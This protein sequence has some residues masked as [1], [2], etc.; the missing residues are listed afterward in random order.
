MKNRLPVLISIIILIIL[1]W[2]SSCL[3]IVVTP[4]VVGSIWKQKNSISHASPLGVTRGEV[5]VVTSLYSL[6]YSEDQCLQE[7]TQTLQPSSQVLEAFFFCLKE[8]MNNA[9]RTYKTYPLIKILIHAW[10]IETC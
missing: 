4:G 7:S 3:L 6:I 2:S 9:K 1:S 10:T 8:P 5:M